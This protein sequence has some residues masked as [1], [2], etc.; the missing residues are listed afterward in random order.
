MC[1]EEGR[2]LRLIR[3]FSRVERPRCH[4]DHSG[5]YGPCTTPFIDRRKKAF[6]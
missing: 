4:L 2:K 3:G 6:L 1:H 5:L